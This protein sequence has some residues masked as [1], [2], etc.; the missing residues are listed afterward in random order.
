MNAGNATK[1]CHLHINEPDHIFDGGLKAEAE[2]VAEELTRSGGTSAGGRPSR[3]GWNPPS[4]VRPSTRP[5][6]RPPVA[7]RGDGAADGSSG[8]R[9]LTTGNQDPSSCVYDNE[10]GRGGE[11]QRLLMG[12]T[13][14]WAGTGSATASEPGFRERLRYL[15]DLHL[16]LWRRTDAG[17]PTLGDPVADHRQKENARAAERLIEDVASRCEAWPAPG[18]ARSAWRGEVRERVRRF[19]EEHL[20]WPDGYRSLLLSDVLGDTTATFVREARAFDPCLRAEEVGQALRNV[21]IMNCLQLLLDQEVSFTP[22]IF[23]YSMLYPLTD[24]LLDDTAVS[25]RTKAGFHHRLG[26][27]LRGERLLPAT[28]HEQ[29][30][31]ALVERIESQYRRDRSP[32]VFE[33]LLAIHRAQG[34]S[35]AQQGNDIPLSRKRILALTVAKGG[36]SVL[37]DGYLVRG[38]LR[39][40]EAELCF[41]YG[42]FLQLLDDLQDVR[43]DTDAGHVTLFTMAARHGTLD[44]VAGRLH[45]FMNLV[46]LGSPR[47][48]GLAHA[49]RRDLVLRSC[50]FLLVGSIARNRSLFGRSFVR[51]VEEC[52]PFT[53]A[54]ASRLQETAERRFRRV[55]GDLVR[56]KGAS[57]LLEL[58]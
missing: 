11:G 39:S 55:G 50:T 14:A 42:V 47:I 45:R 22:A 52:W 40:D 53:L 1:R 21:W 5:D 57:S 58:L 6:A 2:R 13:A 28:A 18:P 4:R 12:A 10:R 41:G 35:L 43:T 51:Q 33:S 34:A 49:D 19:G 15:E 31:F 37:A 8:D 46:M 24:N 54:T 48:A 38:D 44:R 17:P 29:K 32:G 26:R 20:G 56:R 3:R 30:V 27:R 9:S 16:E 25:L 7:E 36:A 23:G